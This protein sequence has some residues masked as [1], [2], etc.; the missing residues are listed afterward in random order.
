MRKREIPW[1]AIFAAVPPILREYYTSGTMETSLAHPYLG[2]LSTPKQK[3][4]AT[5]TVAPSYCAGPRPSPFEGSQRPDEQSLS[6]AKPAWLLPS[7]YFTKIA[8]TW[9]QN[10]TFPRFFS[11]HPHAYSRSRRTNTSFTSNGSRSPPFFLGSSKLR[12]SSQTSTIG[13][14]NHYPGMDF[15]KRAVVS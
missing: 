3:D 12:S 15:C 1:K 7:T 6:C 10:Y 5:A 2:C 14:M 11:T 4:A 9:H 8:R 13:Y